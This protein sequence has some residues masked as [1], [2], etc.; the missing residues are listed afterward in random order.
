VTVVTLVVASAAGL[1]GG[2]VVPAIR[3][4]TAG[5]RR[6]GGGLLLAAVAFIAAALLLAVWLRA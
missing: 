5:D 4:F 2:L 6:V 3:A 1:G